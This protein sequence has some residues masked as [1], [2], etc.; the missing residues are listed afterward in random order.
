VIKYLK[1]YAWQIVSILFNF[2]SVFIVTPYI[3]ANQSLYGIYSIVT[4]AYLFI[5]YADF[6]FLSAGMKYA[7]ESYAQNDKKTEIEVIGFSGMVFFTFVVI[8]AIGILGIAINP[9]I[10]V[11]G[12]KNTHEFAI[13]RE[14]L[15][16]LAIFCPV[17]V[18]QRIIQIIY[19]IRLQDYKFQRI[20]IVSNL[21]KVLAALVF[22][23]NG[24]Y[25]IVQY[26][27]FSQIC[28]L[29][30][31][32]GGVYIA[33]NNLNYDVKLL[34]KSFKFSKK[35]FNK[36]KK[37]AFTSI[38]LTLAWI[39]Y[40]ELDPFVI[41]KLLGS[42]QVAVYAIGITII[43]YFRSLFGILFTPF[44]AR[45]NHFIGLKDKDGLKSIFLKVMVVFLPVTVFPIIVIFFTTR[46]FILIWVG[47][48]YI[49][50]IGIAQILVACYIFSFITYPS[51]ILIMANERVKALYFTSGLQPLIFWLGIM[52]TF[53][54]WGLHS[55]AYFK[56]IAF[57]LEAVV[58]LIIILRY[59]DIKFFTFAKKIV[60]PIIIPI[61]IV[62]G[63]VLFI[64]KYLPVDKNKI[65]LVY[66][67]LSNGFIV[68]LGIIIYYFTSS[69]FKKFISNLFSDL[70]GG[71]RNSAL[72]KRYS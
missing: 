4:A 19:G 70:L 38:F 50:S 60:S 9:Q 30:A 69:V 23:S 63:A 28:T 16:T 36:T 64:R 72:F 24:K 44:I 31:V 55:F 65:Y 20:L 57:F 22:F 45:F 61:I 52:F 15:I 46:N 68:L 18:L 67:I 47:S 3:S 11:S 49:D 34:F 26:F 53:K 13:A 2:A 71:V 59:L 51:A 7:A 42:K 5:S 41:G 56:F 66:Y 58:N 37:L 29:G 54:Y 21:I 17:F 25:L 48:M 40:Y 12:I 32:I 1:I 10:L 62:V 35:L 27:L 43:T 8:Y 6:G 39:L 33:K 14:L